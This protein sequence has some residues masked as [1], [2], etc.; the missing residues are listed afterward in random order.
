MT[1]TSVVCLL[2]LVVAACAGTERPAP[3]PAGDD[4]TITLF[5]AE[6]V[7]EEGWQHLPLRG[8]T[9]YRMSPL[10]GDIAIR[11]VGRESASGLIRR[12]EVDPRECQTLEWRW[13]VDRLQETA[14]LR[15]KKREDVAASIFLLFGDPGFMS[16]PDPVPTLRYVWT[17]GR[18]SKGEVIDNPYLPGTVRS[19]VVRTGESDR[20][21]TEHR[22]VEEDFARA[23]G[24]APA[25]MIHAIALFTDN[26][27]T[28]E[29]AIAYYRW[30][31]I[32]CDRDHERPAAPGA[33]LFQ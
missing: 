25:A 2:A 13:R 32:R 11:A 21:F 30:A 14:D 10:D 18:H 5:D 15:Q 33:V 20:W 27:Q 9:E 3:A 29:P 6:L 26:D 1:R 7:L 24:K 12:V 19:I 8:K 17:N 28:K 31:R 16:N 23:F 22:N 4:R